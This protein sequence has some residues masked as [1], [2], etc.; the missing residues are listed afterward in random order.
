MNWFCFK[1]GTLIFLAIFVILR[2][3]AVPI[4]PVLTNDSAWFL[5]HSFW[6]RY[7]NEPQLIVF[8]AGTKT[9]G[10]PIVMSIWAAV[11]EWI[12][13]DRLSS[14]VLGHR[15]L[16]VGAVLLLL[17]TGSLA[18]WPLVLFFVSNMVITHH[19][20]VLA[21]GVAIPFAII[22]ACSVHLY[23]R[24]LPRMH[25]EEGLRIILIAISYVLLIVITYSILILTKTPYLVL[26]AVLVYCAFPRLE[27]VR[28]GVGD[29]QNWGR[30]GVAL[31]RR[32]K[33]RFRLECS[34]HSAIFLG[35]IFLGLTYGVLVA[36]NYYVRYGQFTLAP[37]PK[38]SLYY[39]T[40]VRAFELHPENKFRPD[41]M[42]FYEG[43]DPFKFSRELFERNGY[44]NY[45]L[46]EPILAARANALIQKVPISMW[47]ERSF[48]LVNG[49]FFGGGMSDVQQILKPTLQEFPFSFRMTH[50]SGDAGRQKL[51]DSYNDGVPPR[52]IRVFSGAF[53]RFFGLRLIESASFDARLFQGVL[54]LIP[55]ALS[56]LVSKLRNGNI[57]SLPVITLLAHFMLCLALS[58]GLCDFWRYIVPVWSVYAITL[59]LEVFAKAPCSRNGNF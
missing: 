51:I 47:R 32:G 45:P 29:A 6:A 25:K 30:Q 31:P 58:F 20:F 53:E 44:Y 11:G 17:C 43:G 38:Y 52:G 15:L 46:N 19:N 23:L 3:L 1:K 28:L 5:E 18:S 57:W 50:F 37:S 10:A 24:L 49:F 59:W 22:F 40:W 8:P 27:L 48:S 26:S 4:F 21:E 7:I 12:G 13:L 42:E 16:L 39:Q 41:L 54:S 33:F 36:S 2:L 35:A 9:A 55:L 56:L 14:I 34:P